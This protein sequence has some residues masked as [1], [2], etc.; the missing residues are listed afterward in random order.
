M[1]KLLKLL[2]RIRSHLP[3]NKGK[4][5]YEE[6]AELYK[7]ELT[8]EDKELAA[9]SHVLDDK[10]DFL[11][12][13]KILPPVSEQKRK[14]FFNRLI[15]K[16]RE[17]QEKSTSARSKAKTGKEKVNGKVVGQL[18]VLIIMIGIFGYLFVSVMG[19]HSSPE[20]TSNIQKPEENTSLSSTE[21]LALDDKDAIFINPFIETSQLN[22]AA[23]NS[24][25]SK[26]LPTIPAF[27][28]SSN[29][30]TAAS[31]PAL[32]AIPGNGNYPRPNIPSFKPPS[33]APAGSGSTNSSVPQ[34]SAATVQGV[35]TGEN[36]NSMAIMSDGAI[37]SAGETYN[38][39]RIAYIGGDGIHF[40]NGNILKYGE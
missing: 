30:V 12:E 15:G 25:G 38:D 8:G 31:K 16:W 2:E 14:S 23:S 7:E 24:D 35:M 22:N 39:G 29:P 27:P 20:K 11:E 37:V 33:M 40:E 26:N 21:M 1:T 6:D 34:Q 28:A 19:N 3:G 4:A 18:A 9:I 36:G 5:M 13:T 10:M 32:P 17:R